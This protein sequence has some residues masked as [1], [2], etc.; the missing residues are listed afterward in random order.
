MLNTVVFAAIPSAIEM[1]AAAV[2]AGV[3]RAE[4]SAYAISLR[5]MIQDTKILKREFPPPL[6]A[7]V[8]DKMSPIAD[9]PASIPAFS[10]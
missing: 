8:T 3:L 10:G 9:N 6:P 4:R 1:T 5:I 2:K 7:D